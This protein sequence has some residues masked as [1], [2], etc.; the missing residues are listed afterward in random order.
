M[1]GDIIPY[2]LQ[3]RYAT[4]AQITDALA[5]PLP[6]RDSL[7]A[8]GVASVH[9]AE[10]W[11]AEAGQP[12]VDLSKSRPE[13]A[14]VNL[15]PDYV[16]RRHNIIPIKKDPDVLYVAMVGRMTLRRRTING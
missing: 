3:K 11:A 13:R 8:A 14:A 12:F 10:A 15:I 9:I 6:L 1:T 7:I 5:K 2:L 16:A 4:D